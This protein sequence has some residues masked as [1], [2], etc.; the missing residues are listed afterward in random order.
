MTKPT[1][2]L[3]QRA[4]AIALT[5]PL[6]A[7][8]LPQRPAQAQ[9]TAILQGCLSNVYCT[10]ALVII[11]GISYLSV[12]Q[13]GQTEYYSYTEDPENDSEAWYDYIWADSQTQAIQRCQRYANEK[14]LIYVTVKRAGSSGQRWECYVRPYA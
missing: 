11:G 4:T 9:A 3:R 10:I 8:I 14:G 5:L 12:S 6:I 13:D 2:R 1:N 7:A